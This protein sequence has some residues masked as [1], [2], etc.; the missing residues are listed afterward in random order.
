ML[1]NIK[2]INK[3]LLLKEDPVFLAQWL[4]NKYLISTINNSTIVSKIIETE[5]YKAPED[6]A[7]HAYGNKRTK[8]TNIFYEEGGLAYIYLCY[9]LHQM[10]NV[11]TGPKEVPHAILIRA[12]EPIQGIQFIKERRKIKN[13]KNY[14][15]GPG[16]LCQALGITNKING[17]DICDK[18]SPV[19]LGDNISIESHKIITSPRVGI[20]YAEEWVD[21]EWRF[22]IKS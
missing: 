10:F 4:L 18:N 5:A 19:W 11:V 17:I 3:S 15:N 14:C 22:T 1:N 21:V 8:R 20:D 13:T 9:G 7:S 6:K 16:K 2:P 12:I